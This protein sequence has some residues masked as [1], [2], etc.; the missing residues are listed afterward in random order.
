MNSEEESSSGSAAWKASGSGGPGAGAAAAE[1]IDT[2]TD[3]RCIRPR[4]WGVEGRSRAGGRL[5]NA[6][7]GEREREKPADGRTSEQ[8]Y[9]TTL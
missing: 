5:K 4:R 9:I 1:L 8:T 3:S 2:K 6:K 7:G